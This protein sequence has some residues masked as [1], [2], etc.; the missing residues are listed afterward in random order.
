MH[1]RP[2][3]DAVQKRR[4]RRLRYVHRQADGRI[5]LKVEIHEH[6]FAKALQRSTRLTAKQTLIRSELE[7][8][9]AGIV[10]DFVERWRDAS[11]ADDL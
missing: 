9:L 7:L 1:D 8:A 4:A 11:L 5:V 2:P 3:T 6:D 10:A